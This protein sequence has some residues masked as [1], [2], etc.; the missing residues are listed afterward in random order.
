MNGQRR[1]SEDG[2]ILA[3]F[4]VS[5]IALVAFAGLS[6]DA[7]GTYAQRRDQ[8]AAAD[9]ASLA[10]ANDYLINGDSS[11]AIARARS[12]AANNGYT[13]GSN[14]TSVGVTVDTSNGV[15]VSVDLTAPH[16]NTFVGVL[17]MATW[18]V[19]THAAALAGFPDT[20]MGAGPF[21]FSIA[22]F[23]NAGTPTYQTDTD[24]GDGNGDVPNN[25]LDFAWTNYGTGNVNT[26][27]VSDIISGAEVVNKTLT[28]G[29]YI[30]Q[31]NNGN[32][33]ALFSDVD[34]YLSGLEMPVAVV[35]NNGNFMGWAM[36]HVTSASGGSSKHI[37]GY[38]L[39]SFISAKLRVSS[40]AANACPRYL[41]SYVLKLS[42]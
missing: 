10:G 13:D 34:T 5:L 35:D 18:S 25:A 20:A 3:I 21:I 17:G 23:N 29:E 9:L 22:A 6:I 37:R 32:H 7:G 11:L 15:Q 28:Y 12:V 27:E 8:Q 1:R 30:G 38:F 19:S 31:H 4:A 24:F 36:F 2:Q 33:T 42:S 26:S 39:S 14:G 40:C 16:K 41:G